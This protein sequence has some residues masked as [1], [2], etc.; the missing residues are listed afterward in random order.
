MSIESYIA[1]IPE[2]HRPDFLCLIEVIQQ[3]IPEGFQETE[4]YNMIGYVVP[5]AI[6]PD[7]YH[8]TP[9]LPLPFINIACQKNFIA[10]YHMGIYSDEELLNW[11]VAEFPKH[12]SK[13]LDMGK[14]C[15][16]FKHGHPI[17]YELIG[18]LIQKMS[19]Q[20]WID[21]YEKMYK[22]K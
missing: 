13:K 20:D 17:P 12:S 22:P 4:S 11:F 15:I 19:V 21:R 8:C 3:H 10:V 14:S 18:Q 6:Y 2:A 9:K 1:G 7:G 5:H 16:R